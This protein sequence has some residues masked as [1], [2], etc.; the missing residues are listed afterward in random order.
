[1]L[2]NLVSENRQPW[3]DARVK[4]KNVMNNDSCIDN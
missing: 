2:W 3:C 4:V 1:M